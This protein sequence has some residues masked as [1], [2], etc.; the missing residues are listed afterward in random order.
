MEE[1]GTKERRNEGRKEVFSGVKNI[2]ESSSLLSII[3]GN[4]IHFLSLFSLFHS[5]RFEKK[6]IEKI[7][8]ARTPEEFVKK[9]FL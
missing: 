1:G 3:S 7:E 9:K 8:K 5:H 4:S 2:I 6:S